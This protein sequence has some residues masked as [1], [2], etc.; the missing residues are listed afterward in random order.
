M[1][2]GSFFRRDDPVLEGTKVVLRMPSSGDYAAWAALRGESREFLSKWE[3]VWAPDELTRKSYRRRLQQYQSAYQLGQAV[4]FFLF[5]RENSILLGGISLSNI[6]RG[7]AQATTI[8]YWMGER[9]AGKGAM[10]DALQCVIPYAFQTLRLHRLEAA[11]IPTNKRS[12]RLLEKAGFQREG[13]MRSY[14]CINGLWQDHYLY[15]RIVGENPVQ[16]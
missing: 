16:T 11:C 10:Y 15:A 3:P 4:S 8:G 13:L 2:T 1:F 6:R 7:A 9:H 14:L 12:V 5:S